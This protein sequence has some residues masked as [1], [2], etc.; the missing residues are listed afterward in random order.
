MEFYEVI[1]GRFSCKKFD[2]RPVEKPQLDAILEAGRLAPTA[3]NL[4]EQH[5]Y[6][7]QS[8][9]GLVKIDKMTPCRYGAVTVL[10]VAFDKNNVFTYPGEKRDSGVEDATIVAAH[11]MLAAKA[12]GVDSCWINFFDPDMV[13]KEFGLPENE[14]VL[15]MLDLG[16]AA[17]GAEP[18]AS[19]SQ[20][21]EISETVTCI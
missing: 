13:A 18:L 7:V 5:I 16:Y 17:E 19:H 15:M 20:R 11:M 2:G 3:K 21:K 9:K 4:Q 1:R 8:E 14:E 6:V 12:E 10:V